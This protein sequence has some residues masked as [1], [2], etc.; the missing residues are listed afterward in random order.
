MTESE[1]DAKQ[2]DSK[3]FLRFLAAGQAT[4]PDSEDNQVAFL[5]GELARLHAER[6]EE[7]FVW[8]V[9]IVVILDLYF[10]LP[11]ENWAGP[12]VIGVLQLIALLVV[13]NK[14]Q[15]NPILPLLDRAAGF[16]KR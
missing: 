5:Q 11:A 1:H 9:C 15:V 12:V 10:L 13:A 7:R 8:I 2:E 16:M 6:Q 4:K 3:V 14:C